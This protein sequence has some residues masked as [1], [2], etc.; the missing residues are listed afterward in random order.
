VRELT[1]EGKE[2]VII[3]LQLFFPYLREEPI[4]FHVEHSHI[5]RVSDRLAINLGPLLVTGERFVPTLVR[6]RFDVS[7]PLSD[8][9]FAFLDP[10]DSLGG[11]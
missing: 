7:D 2:N 5:C 6:D 3:H 1:I 8:D 4:P 10:D 9:E 11:Q